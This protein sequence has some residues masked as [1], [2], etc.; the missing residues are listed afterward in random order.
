MKPKIVVTGLGAVTPVGLDVPTT[1]AAVCAGHSGIGPTTRFD[2]RDHAI[3]ISAEVKGFDP[4][5]YFS[6]KKARRLDRF[7]QFGLVATQE[8]LADAQLDLSRVRPERVGVYIGSAFGGIETLTQQM[9]AFC[10]ERRRVSPFLIPMMI[11][12]MAAGQISITLGLKGPSMSPM[13]ACAAGTDAIGQ[14]AAA[15]Q[16]GDAEVMICGGAEAPLTP[17]I[18]AGFEALGVLA[19]GNGCPQQ[20]CRPFDATREGCVIGEGAGIVVLE[21]LD[22]AQRR[23]AR[24]Y[25]EVVGYGST[26]DAAHITSPTENGEGI[27]R[28]MCLALHQAGLPPSAVGYLNA[29]GSGTRHNDRSETAGIKATFADHAPHLAISSTKASTGHL[30]G[31]AGAIEAILCFKALETQTLPPTLNYT[32]PDPDCDLD[33]VPN[34]VRPATLAVALSNS[35]GFG[36]HNATLA[37]RR[38]G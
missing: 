36:G 15:I 25:A 3:K 8:A 19:A 14:A 17:I 18:M 6:A 13:T 22:H 27:T 31:G 9:A 16:R 35:V 5:D 24:I 2:T 12:N 7:S 11:Q 34:Q 38:W 4:R 26:S 30:M 32:H 21:R 37:L 1:W 28:A 23:G 29:H 20:A 33:Y 10:H